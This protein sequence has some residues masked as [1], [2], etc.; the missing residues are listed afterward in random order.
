MTKNTTRCVPE[1]ILANDRNSL[2]YLSLFEGQV[3]PL[4]NRLSNPSDDWK[5]VLRGSEYSL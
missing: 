4:F 1:K 3:R 2:I 5:I